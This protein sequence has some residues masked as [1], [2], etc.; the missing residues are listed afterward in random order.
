[1]D[2]DRPGKGP[3][4][5]LMS[6]RRGSSYT[7][8]SSTGRG[9]GT[10][11]QP[12]VLREM[13]LATDL[14][15]QPKTSVGDR[16]AQTQRLTELL[17]HETASGSAMLDVPIATPLVSS[18][19]VL[20]SRLLRPAMPLQLRLRVC[21]LL[22]A[23]LRYAEASTA[24]ANDDMPQ[25]AAQATGW[26]ATLPTR[27][28]ST[29]DRALLYKLVIALRHQDDWTQPR[30]VQEPEHAFATLE[31][32]L[33]TLEALTRDG[34]DVLPF[35]GFFATLTQW[36]EA[37][38]GAMLMLR[39]RRTYN[40][41]L[42]EL[43]ES[44]VH[45]ALHLLNATVKFHA[46]RLEVEQIHSTLWCLAHLVLQPRVPIEA[47]TSPPVEVQSPQL[48]PLSEAITFG[49]PQ[50]GP[51]FTAPRRRQPPTRR[52]DDA[53]ATLSDA[54]MPD[55]TREDVTAIASTLNGAACFAFIP[56]P[57]V[58]PI[59]YALCRVLGLRSVHVPPTELFEEL[60]LRPE[61]QPMELWSLL[62]NVLRS[63]IV[64]LVLRAVH[65]L[66]T[67][68][69]R[70]PLSVRVGALRFLHIALAWAAEEHAEN[71]TRDLAALLPASLVAGMLRGALA[72][73]E[74]VLEAAV[75]N[76]LAAYVPRDGAAPPLSAITGASNADTW[77]LVAALAPVVA[78]HMEHRSESLSRVILM[79]F[80]EVLGSEHEGRPL[81][82]LEPLAPLFWPLAPLL[83]DE[84]IS[85]MVRTMQEQHAYMP[86]HPQWLENLTSLL[87]TFYP[88]ESVY[89]SESPIA[90]APRARAEAVAIVVS[91]FKAVQ[92]LPAYRDELVNRIAVPVAARALRLENDF[93]IGEPLRQIGQHVFIVCALEGRE[94]LFS[95]LLRAYF[96]S[97][98]RAES[99][100]RPH[101]RAQ[102]SRQQSVGPSNAAD[103]RDMQMRFQRAV[104]SV[105]DLV[106]V[107][108]K[109]A[110]ALPSTATM[111]QIDVDA[112]V[113]HD[114]ARTA[115]LA[116][117]REML[118]LVQSNA[119][120]G[121]NSDAD[122]SLVPSQVRVVTLQWLLHL[123]A[124]RQ[125]RVFVTTSLGPEA[126]TLATLLQHGVS[127]STRE[128]SPERSGTASSEA[129]DTSR[130]RPLE[131]HRDMSR[132]RRLESPR[133]R[134]VHSPRAHS[135]G[136]SRVRND[137]QHSPS[138]SRAQ[139]V[140]PAVAAAIET[141]ELP[142]SEEYSSRL[143]TL[144]GSPAIEITGTAPSEVLS[145]F[146]HMGEN[147]RTPRAMLPTSEYLAALL[148]LL[149]SEADWEIVSLIVTHLPEQL[150]NKHFFCG[151]AALRQVRALHGVLCP[152]LLGQALFPNLVL[153]DSVR[154]TDLHAALYASLKVL[155]SYHRLFTREQQDELIEAFIAGLTKSQN[156]AQPCVRA[157][158]MACHE[159][160][161]S[162]TRLVPNILMKLSTIMSSI[163]MSVHILE[164]LAEVRSIPAL[165]ANFTEAD[166]RRVFG[167]ALQYI[168][169]HE[170]AAARGDL[171]SSP[172]RFSLSQ[173][174]M[175]L[176]YSN[177]A[178]WFMTLRL[179]DRAKHAPYI[180]QGL[181]LA[182]EGRNTLSDQT[183][184]CLDF[185]ARFTY[186]NAAAKP[187][188]SL[189][190]QIIAQVDPAK[191]LPKS[192]ST[193]TWLLGKGLV[194]VT[195]LP[196][197]D[198]FEVLIR[199]PSGTVSA[200][201]LLENTPY[202]AL[203][204]EISTAD[205]LADMLSR[206][207]EELPK[208]LEAQPHDSTTEPSDAEPPEAPEP[209]ATDEPRRRL[210]TLDPAF[211]ALQIMR[212]PDMIADEAPL[213]VPDDPATDRV[214]RAMDLTPV[215]DFHKIGLLYVGH[216]Q[217]T[218]QEILSNT[219]GSAAYMRFLS[220]LGELVLLRGQ[221]E[222]YTGGLDRQN[223]EHGKYAYVWRDTIKQIVF[224]TATLMP[225]RE[226]DPNCSMKKALI[227]NDWVHI[228]FNESNRPYEFGTI[229][230]QFNFVN[231][232]ISP[233][234][235]L[236][237]GLDMY[238]VN[239]ETYCT[240]HFPF[241]Y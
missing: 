114:R 15:L 233:H 139:S 37:A 219:T 79:Q 72:Q 211:L 215:L 101:A 168:Q 94:D 50:L 7:F 159:L 4:P 85:V 129:P 208:V 40:K 42:V 197:Q 203:G 174:V 28:L 229:A 26:D 122:E 71:D 103:V 192:N 43:S 80:V 165:Y 36:V 213:R 48:G 39:T 49:T 21:D 171:A 65:S 221:Q 109:L 118:R 143:W 236:R 182:N 92:D 29:L 137:S 99:I 161:K 190:R 131:T 12:E 216:A 17:R 222:V 120:F 130:G 158:V 223:D 206:M 83:S 63:H 188:R 110:F 142:S 121:L 89:T 52:S 235:N 5:F 207:R 181:V 25:A 176:A 162:F 53:L 193:A 102:H 194:T 73:G 185:L 13:H 127:D 173:Y 134:F 153:P 96:E 98:C 104:R 232:V 106:W 220:C 16:L 241:M 125:H 128:S 140:A 60:S 187:S 163:T 54:E 77:E 119:P 195:P 200:V 59:V 112:K 100:A 166:Y 11:A 239:D 237:E 170:G 2:A 172:A 202:N 225:N 90:L 34:R 169:F 44:C 87:Y 93:S 75:L 67:T 68:R 155:V 116:I 27:A 69:S 189:M 55:F 175:M 115:C 150:A 234:S 167:I 157:L 210:P 156:T 45:R 9:A 51:M 3:L 209:S 186:S 196:R 230:S 154:R 64:H 199:R 62:Q 78:R 238:E 97:I 32:Q 201:A 214:L 228:V 148:A 8:G 24:Q 117:F 151:P 84:T 147:D 226:D 184:V 141:P 113:V 91:V 47:P 74:D 107:F 149:Q 205:V 240:L 41:D 152:L 135:R 164:L 6:F 19:T 86:S 218:E 183:Q 224:H 198:A 132:G 57:C 23:T 66:L 33:F 217:T 126:Y 81:L 88:S 146:G 180:T 124:D 178:L 31:C 105:Q 10:S 95:T 133:S 177:I 123:R 204:D 76:L 136:R 46:S 144:P 38:W 138:Q 14:L 160:G 22:G 179:A 145:V 20:C 212:Y 231:I 35:R 58:A 30:I 191:P 111:V 18:L 61:R 227:G 82:A 56:A 70:A 108:H 1:M